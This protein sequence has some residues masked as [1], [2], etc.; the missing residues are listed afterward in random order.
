M[1]V[2]VAGGV[3]EGER[4]FVGVEGGGG[5]GVGVPAVAGSGGP[6]EGVHGVADGEADVFGV[7]GVD[8]GV[9]GSGP[10]PG[11]WHVG[12]GVEEVVF[13]VGDV[14]E[15]FGWAWL[16]GCEPAAEHVEGAGG[17][18]VAG[19]FPLFGGVGGEAVHDHAAE[20]DL[21]VH[22][23]FVDGW[24]A[25]AV[26]DFEGFDEAGDGGGAGAALD[27]VLERLVDEAMGVGAF[28]AGGGFRAS[29]GC[30]FGSGS[31]FGL[32]LGFGVVGAAGGEVVAGVPGRG[33][34][35][36]GVGCHWRASR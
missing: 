18:E 10:I 29:F 2:V 9:I 30:G 12:E 23:F 14:L 11:P 17:E 6:G 4:G 33:G 27:G 32:G 3:D 1:E 21:G 26:G 16:P 22:L 7:G 20:G 19:E 35:V 8:D 34:L 24:R 36:A 28:G 25:E 5:G 31:G 13:R 15:P